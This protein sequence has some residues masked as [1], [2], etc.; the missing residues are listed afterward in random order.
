MDILEAQVWKHFKKFKQEKPEMDVFEDK[1][2][3]FGSKGKNTL[4]SSISLENIL[5]SF[6]FL[7][8]TT[9]ILKQWRGSRRSISPEIQQ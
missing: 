5:K 2:K 7:M 1:K 3:N 9:C 8:D 4:K 6:N